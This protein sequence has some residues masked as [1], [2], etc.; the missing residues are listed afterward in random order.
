MPVGAKNAHGLPVAATRVAQQA[1]WGVASYVPVGTPFAVG[2]QYYPP[3]TVAMLTP[4]YC[5]SSTC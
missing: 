1:G 5:I 4:L 2:Q 3:P